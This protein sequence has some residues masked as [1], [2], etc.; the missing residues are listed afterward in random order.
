MLPQ[1]SPSVTGG[2]TLVCTRGALTWYVP[3]W[4]PPFDRR[5]HPN[6]LDTPGYF[7][8][9]QWSL[10]LDSGSTQVRVLASRKASFRNGTR[11]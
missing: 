9:P 6:F 8:E 7:F 11:R 10:P 1:W 2:S 5:E 3:Q 4:S